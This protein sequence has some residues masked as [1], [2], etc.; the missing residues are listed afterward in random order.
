MAC[1][2]HYVNEEE[3]SDTGFLKALFVISLYLLA[4][5]FYSSKF[6]SSKFD[7]TERNFFFVQT[8]WLLLLSKA[9][10]SG[11]LI[12]LWKQTEIRKKPFGALNLRLSR[13][14]RVEKVGHTGYNSHP[15]ALVYLLVSQ[16]Q[17]F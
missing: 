11:Q 8:Q 16:L 5:W 1:I 4:G 3:V 17:K 13:W 9:L 2:F 6:D 15:E 7:Q 14:E 12:F 10:C